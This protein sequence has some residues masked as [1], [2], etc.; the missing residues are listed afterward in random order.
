MKM[1]GYYQ[2]EKNHLN[3]YLDI[4]NKSESYQD[5]EG[6]CIDIAYKD[7]DF[8]LVFLAP[9]ELPDKKDI[10]ALIE[11]LIELDS[12]IANREN[13]KK[14]YLEERCVIFPRLHRHPEKRVHAALANS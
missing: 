7:A 5:D 9:I 14:H 1:N 11:T 6:I 8:T 12:F 3:Q 13:A 2:L 10:S 4:L